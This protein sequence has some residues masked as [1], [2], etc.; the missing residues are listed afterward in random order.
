MGKYRFEA[1]I[2]WPLGP[3][4]PRS[5]NLPMDFF[6]PYRSWVPAPGSRSDYCT[7]DSQLAH[8]ELVVLQSRAFTIVVPEVD[9]SFFL[10]GSRSIWQ[11][12]T[13]F[14][15]TYEGKR[16]ISSLPCLHPNQ[17]AASSRNGKLTVTVAF[18]P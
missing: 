18:N 13:I 6:S 4:S 2:V 8:L 11:R 9:G 14:L 5:R 10:Q 7:N 16:Q 15:S 12:A 3:Q 1:A 17:P